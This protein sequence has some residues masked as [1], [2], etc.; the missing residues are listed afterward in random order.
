ML[1]N[2]DY[3]E[4]YTICISGYPENEPIEKILPIFED[5]KKWLNEIELNN[6]P[7]IKFLDLLITFA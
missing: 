4:F 7:L 3:L 5:I 6:E 2:T 1:K